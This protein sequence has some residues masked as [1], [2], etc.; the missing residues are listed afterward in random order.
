MTIDDQ[1]AAPDLAF[2]PADDDRDRDNLRAVL[3]ELIGRR[4]ALGLTQPDI[5]KKLHT[6]T[7][8]IAAL[9]T[10]SAGQAQVASV[11][12]Y[13]RAVGARL[14]FTLEPDASTMDDPR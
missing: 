8:R 9:E 5:A 12:R 14:R 10:G 4:K 2:V 1:D 3:G 11:Q 7:Y 6:R 13:A